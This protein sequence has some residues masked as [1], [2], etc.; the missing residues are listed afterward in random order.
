[1]ALEDLSIKTF[2]E[3]AAL[4]GM[5]ENVA[6]DVFNASGTYIA[7]GIGYDDIL[8]LLSVSKDAPESY[9][10][11]VINFN[12]IKTKRPEITT[13]TEWMNARKEYK[14][15]LQQYGLGDIATNEYADQFLNNGV[16]VN[17][18]ADRLNTAYYA[19]VNA[20]SALKEQLKTYFPS[21]SNADLV[22]NLLGVGKTT[23]ELKKQIG[24][25]GIQAEAET[26]GIKSTLGA[27]ELYSQGV[28][29]E[30]AR[31][32]FQTIAQTGQA[33]EQAAGRAGIDTKG[34]QTELEKEQLLGLASQRR[35]QTQSA[36][37]NI[38]S[39]QSGTANI[40]LGKNVAG[41][42]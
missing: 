12:Q 2:M 33:I 35:K 19:I 39:G 21:L 5:P 1:M 6:T 13:V 18:A 14:Y 27:Q 16:S 10:N 41:R 17:E 37:Q 20:D 22:K 24:M 25:A 34:L 7:E 4:T 28:T 30:A 9:K 40:S 32:G 15:Y 42:I 3:Y 11:F 8:N 26:A 38:F 36:E 23:E 31:K 29:R